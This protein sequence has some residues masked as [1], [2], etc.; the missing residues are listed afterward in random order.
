MNLH[1]LEFIANASRYSDEDAVRQHLV[2]NNE[3]ALE[4]FSILFDIQEDIHCVENVQSIDRKILIRAL[5]MLPLKHE[6]PRKVIHQ[7]VNDAGKSLKDTQSHRECLIGD[8][9]IITEVIVFFASINLDSNEDLLEDFIDKVCTQICSV[10]YNSGNISSDTEYIVKAMFHVLHAIY[11]I[12]TSINQALLLKYKRDSDGTKN[13]KEEV[14][15]KILNHNWCIAES[16]PSIVLVHLLYM[17]FNEFTL[18]D[19]QWR[20]VQLKVSNQIA[21]MSDSAKNLNLITTTV[22]QGL[23]S[24][25]NDES[26]I[27]YKWFSIIIH[28]YCCA[29]KFEDVSKTFINSFKQLLNSFCPNDL[30]A[31][32]H[33]IT[34][35][36]DNEPILGG[37][38]H[39]KS[40]ARINL[41][42]LTVGSLS[43][44]MNRI[45][46]FQ[47][48]RKYICD[49]IF[50]KC[51]E[52]VSPNKEESDDS[53]HTLYSCIQVWQCL[54]DV[55]WVDADSFCLIYSETETETKKCFLMQ[56]SIIIRNYWKDLVYYLIV[57]NSISSKEENIWMVSIVSTIFSLFPSIRKEL[58]VR[59]TC[60]LFENRSLHV[61]QRYSLIMFLI[62]VGKRHPDFDFG[63]IIM[64]KLGLISSLP[65]PSLV[66]GVLFS[67]AQHA[68]GR[69]AFLEFFLSLMEH[70]ISTCDD[71]NTKSY[72]I[73]DG[74]MFLL[75][76]EFWDFENEDSVSSHAL[77]II[78]DAIVTGSLQSCR[79]DN[80]LD[81]CHTHRN[82]VMEKILHHL[83][84]SKLHQHALSRIEAAII[85]CLLPTV[86]II[87]H[88]I[89]FRFHSNLEENDIP[90]LTH[91]LCYLT[92]LRI[93]E[94]RSKDL[95][96]GRYF[97]KCKTTIV[98]FDGNVR[99]GQL[100]KTILLSMINLIWEEDL[101]SHDNEFEST[102]LS[103]SIFCN[104]E[105][106][107]WSESKY[108]PIW[109][110]SIHVPSEN[111]SNLYR[112]DVHGTTRL[113]QLLSQTFL[114]FTFDT[115]EY[116]Q[117]DS[118]MFSIFLQHISNNL[119][120]SRDEVM[121]SSG[122]LRQLVFKS[123]FRSIIKL[124]QSIAPEISKKK[125]PTN[126]SSLQSIG[127][128]LISEYADSDILCQCYKSCTKYYSIFHDMNILRCLI[129]IIPLLETTGF[130][131]VREFLTATLV[132]VENMISDFS[133]RNVTHTELKFL[134][135]VFQSISKRTL[136]CNRFSEGTIYAW[137]SCLSS[138]SPIFEEG[139]NTRTD[140]AVLRAMIDAQLAL[141][142]ADQ[143]LSRAL[144]EA[145]SSVLYKSSFS[146]S[147]QII[148][149]W[150][151]DSH[152]KS[153]SL[154]QIL[155]S[156]DDLL[157][158]SKTV[159]IQFLRKLI[160]IHWKDNTYNLT[161]SDTEI[162]RA[163][164]SKT[165]EIFNRSFDIMYELH[166]QDHCHSIDNHQHQV[167][168]E[169]CVS[170]TVTVF[171]RLN[172]LCR[173]LLQQRFFS[174]C[175]DISEMQTLECVSSILG[176]ENENMISQLLSLVS[177]RSDG[178]D[179][180]IQVMIEELDLL[181]FEISGHISQMNK[182][183]ERKRLKHLPVFLQMSREE[184]EHPISSLRN[185]LSSLLNNVNNGNDSF[186]IRTKRKS[187]QLYR[188]R[189]SNNNVINTWR[190]L[191]N[192]QDE[193]FVTDHFIDL[194]DFIVEG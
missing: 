187:R 42:L 11:N 88:Q 84:I 78:S 32:L 126:L 39:I 123:F 183:K 97:T 120:N 177:K 41:I 91:A 156:S 193:R 178:V 54:S 75:Y 43:E 15:C 59:I 117:L 184:K 79:T 143:N 69:R 45:E 70:L 154:H 112:S 136:L 22:L 24:F 137:L 158:F 190:K 90:L 146:F 160:S 181:L 51:Q 102:H 40:N 44:G 189:K 106:E 101:S 164:L 122:N 76:E 56:D 182:N 152:N 28:L 94:N 169:I 4:I 35:C 133:T 167:C 67:L 96:I 103:Q 144:V 116:S 98:K 180:T 1:D 64:E 21:I 127:G 186:S 176:T 174:F 128:F 157:A 115:W 149:V 29:L 131:E 130:I 9:K 107:S 57:S 185:Y 162:S 49:I 85:F 50:E 58:A 38:M 121:I 87:N 8:H 31:I 62:I 18:S 19:D 7:L 36:K 53:V 71:D 125:Q 142:L 150:D 14:L 60:N 170:T 2:N 26:E 12:S 23:A 163:Y 3:L 151:S 145:Q 74:I 172:A 33:I 108:L 168:L 80:D 141:S 82:L 134:H 113:K 93:K 27:V 73:I 30:P 140:E 171:R 52:K 118:D 86:H 25:D 148:E 129:K 89:N 95:T 139:I 155:K 5:F 194:N 77:A 10:L 192:E 166:S 83:R 179:K 110:S 175:L 135:T 109:C 72:F 63:K 147:L 48:A 6:L 132:L 111:K 16:T 81:S 153:N 114:A 65:T 105:L 119:T 99:S 13:L 55:Q 46:L 47:L 138:C 161:L 191:D 188:D 66:T 124:H 173:K 61:S 20:H 104:V 34:N 37:T 92:D 100:G 159:A 68:T 17:C 165:V